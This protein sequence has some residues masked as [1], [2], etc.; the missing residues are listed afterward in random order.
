MFGSVCA[1]TELELAVSFWGKITSLDRARARSDDKLA[2]GEERRKKKGG[3]EGR[4][5]G[6]KGREEG[7]AP[8]LKSRGRHLAGREILGKYKCSTP[9]FWTTW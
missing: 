7:V 4:K 9:T 3:K 8:L 6:G 1:L 2:Q 5:E